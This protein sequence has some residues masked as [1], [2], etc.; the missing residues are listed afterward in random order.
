[1]DLRD[2][3]GTERRDG[4]GARR[5]P[6]PERINIRTKQGSSS[7]WVSSWTREWTSNISPAAPPWESHS[8]RHQISRLWPPKTP[9]CLATSVE[10]EEP[11]ATA[12]GGSIPPNSAELRDGEPNSSRR[13]PGLRV[14]WGRWA[15]KYRW[16][17]LEAL[18]HGS[19]TPQTA[20]VN[21]TEWMQRIH[22]RVCSPHGSSKIRSRVSSKIGTRVPSAFVAVVGPGRTP[23]VSRRRPR[24]PRC[25][26][27]NPASTDTEAA[28]A[29]GPIGGDIDGWGPSYEVRI[30]DPDRPLAPLAP[31]E[32]L[33]GTAG[34]PAQGDTCLAAFP[35]QG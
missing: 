13:P 7:S 5:P 25:C 31:L 26:R 1:M 32:F 23:V 35:R 33:E 21:R 27:F 19:A 22:S 24:G 3:S 2:A 14:G 28:A 18:R 8:R 30:E 15:L 17:Q 6:N 11:P 29:A 9:M 10:N 12:R 34:V 20:D 16:P 4:I